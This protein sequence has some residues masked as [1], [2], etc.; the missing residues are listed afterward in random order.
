[1]LGHMSDL[2]S[3]PWCEASHETLPVLHQNGPVRRIMPDGC[4]NPI[5]DGTKK[6]SCL[7]DGGGETG[8]GVSLKQISP[9]WQMVS[10]ASRKNWGATFGHQQVTGTWSE[11]EKEHI[12]VLELRAIYY[13]LREME[14]VVKGKKVAI[15]SDNTTV[16][17][18][19]RRQGGG[20]SPGSC[21]D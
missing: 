10:D 13:A 11:K 20:R 21:S 15:F 12:N 17:S 19:I 6:K 7:V 9:D 1:M 5:S 3:C 4:L 2:E 8:K 14:E 16:L 18:Y